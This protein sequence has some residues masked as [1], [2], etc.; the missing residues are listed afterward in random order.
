MAEIMSLDLAK[1]ALTHRHDAL[2]Q[3][4]YN[5]IIDPKNTFCLLNFYQRQSFI[6]VHIQSTCRRQN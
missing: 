1:E 3:V 6:L 5:I 2:D 4:S